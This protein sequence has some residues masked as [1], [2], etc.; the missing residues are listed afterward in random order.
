M[1]GNQEGSSLELVLEPLHKKI[2]A[3]VADTVVR[4]SATFTGAISQID[5]SKSA[6]IEA[7][8]DF[9][10]GSRFWHG[11]LHKPLHLCQSHVQ[12]FFTLAPHR[13]EELGRCLFSLSHPSSPSPFNTSRSETG[14]VDD[15]ACHIV[16]AGVRE[17]AVVP[18]ACEAQTIEHVD[19]SFF[20]DEELARIALSFHLS[21]DLLCQGML[22]AWYSEECPL[23][24]NDVL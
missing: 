16:G 13:L 18:V 5:S 22:G 8:I 10:A 14:Y 4:L 11:S 19:E 24:E 9:L 1:Q 12:C 20:E 2:D 15:F 6:S 3:E 23:A 21:T 7:E 17:A